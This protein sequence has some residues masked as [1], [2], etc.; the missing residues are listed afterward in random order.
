MT[1]DNQVHH[2]SFDGTVRSE[3]TNCINAK[4]HIGYRPSSPSARMR[5]P[6]TPSFFNRDLTENQVF[7]NSIETCFGI[8]HAVVN[9]QDS[10]FQRI[11]T[12]GSEQQVIHKAMFL[13]PSGL[14]SMKRREKGARMR[15]DL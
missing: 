9:P 15:L 2:R 10:N 4:C 12:K 1:E 13:I 3:E 5:T 6:L 14:L 8:F 11:D 7:L